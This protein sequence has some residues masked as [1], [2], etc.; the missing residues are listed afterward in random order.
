V[1]RSR[2]AHRV[3]LRAR[4]L[5]RRD[6][7]AE[8][9]PHRNREALA[10]DLRPRLRAERRRGGEEQKSGG[11]ERRRRV[12]EKS[13]GGEEERPVPCAAWEADALLTS[14]LT[15]RAV[16]GNTVFHVQQRALLAQ[17]K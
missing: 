10:R 5:E 1:G 16:S 13:G 15:S 3:A 17:R 11:E 4:A 6:I 14:L 2:G 7:E 9:A 8:Y 12:E